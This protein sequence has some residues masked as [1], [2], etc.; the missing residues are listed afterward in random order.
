MP[1]AFWYN[2][3]IS[4][5]APLRPAP[6]KTVSCGDSSLPAD[7]IIEARARI[8]PIDAHI[9]FSI[10]PPLKSRKEYEMFRDKSL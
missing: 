3:P 9:L 10:F 7:D 2:C 1:L 8:S 4:L 5:K 6:Q